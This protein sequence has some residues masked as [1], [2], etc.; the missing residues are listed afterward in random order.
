MTIT[1]PF[2]LL[3]LFDLVI[4]K[5]GEYGIG[6]IDVT[7][8]DWRKNKE[9]ISR[10]YAGIST[11]VLI[12]SFW[13]KRKNPTYAGISPTYSSFL[14]INGI[15]STYPILYSFF[16]LFPNQTGALSVA[17]LDFVQINS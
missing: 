15:T 6:H 17:H 4:S 1:P 10:S 13:W 7:P 16:C 5:K 12:L 14:I 9:G 2:K 8:N 3:P 11:V